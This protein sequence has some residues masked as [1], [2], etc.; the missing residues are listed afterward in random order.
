MEG[1]R[2]M[3]KLFKEI[4]EYNRRFPQS[5]I[6]PDGIKRSL[7]A[8]AQSK[9]RMHNGMVINPRLRTELYEDVAEWGSTSTIWEDIGTRIY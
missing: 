5:A 3:N 6:T 8:K 2:D 9:A 1:D 4:Y 7:R